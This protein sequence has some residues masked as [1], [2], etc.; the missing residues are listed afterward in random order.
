MT[1]TNES[2]ATAPGRATYDDALGRNI[3]AIHRW[4]VDQGL[5]GAAD[6]SGVRGP[7]PPARRGRGAAVARLRRRADVAPAMGRL[8]LTWLR[9]QGRGRAGAPRARR[10]IR[11]RPA[12]SPFALLMRGGAIQ[13]RS[14]LG[15]PSLRRRLSGPE[16]QLDFPVLER[17]AAAGATDYFA[18]IVRFG[19]AGDPSYGNGIG[20]SFATDRPGGFSDDDVRLIQAVLPAASLAIMS[21]AGHTHRLR[22]AGR[23][24]R[25]RCRP[26]GACRRGRARLGRKHPGGA[27]LCRYPRL[28]GDRRFAARAC[29]RSS[30]STRCSRR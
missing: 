29:R 11:P 10:R 1:A 24:S 14:E 26:P 6:G 22:T 15:W 30:C 13:P 19:P 5:R 25:R 21:D 27:V 12:D 17:L 16:A 9:E 4:A 2:R 8:F 3:I 7:V 18:Q 23:L 20:Y 28:H